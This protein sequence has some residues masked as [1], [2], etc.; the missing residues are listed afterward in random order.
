MLM[1]HMLSLRG[2]VI[3]I[4]IPNWWNVAWR[5]LWWC[6][7]MMVSS[8]IIILSVQSRFVFVS[9]PHLL[10]IVICLLRYFKILCCIRSQMFGPWSSS[11]RSTNWV[12]LI[13]TW[14]LT[15]ISFLLNNKLISLPSSFRILHFDLHLSL[16]WVT[17]ILIVKSSEF[18]LW[19]IRC[20]FRIIV[21]LR[22][23]SRDRDSTTHR[24]NFRFSN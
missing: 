19:L 23:N 7:S 22:K 14:S 1:N 5:I 13:L 16:S 15:V 18:L 8:R 17:L 24:I 20:Q 2:I 3:L 9:N 12:W 11:D 4:F 10:L 6:T 21:S